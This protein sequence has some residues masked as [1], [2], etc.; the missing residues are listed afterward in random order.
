MDNQQI[1][2]Q[3]NKQAEIFANWAAGKNAEYL[4]AF[5]DFSGIAPDDK[6]LDVA[7]GP[8]EFTC[9]AARKVFAAYGVDISDKEIEIAK[10]RSN[11]LGLGNIYFDRSDVEKIP[12]KD[13]FFSKV[14]CKSA[15]HHFIHPTAVFDEMR[16][17]CIPGG[18]ISIQDIVAFE[19]GYVTSFF[20]SF[21]KLV[22]AS[23]NS[24][25]KTEE[26]NRLFIDHK[27][28]KIKESHFEANLPVKEYIGHAVQEPENR[29]KINALL[30]DGLNDRKIAEY[31]FFNEGELYCKRFGYLILG[32]KKQ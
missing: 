14:V 22:D 21:D 7:C 28:K 18:K 16:R 3:F 29:T 6:L 19:N 23:H 26:L 1:R 24:V 8:G 13:N 15:F 4:Q 9:Y 5:Y 17:C 10:N 31:L 12:Y 30:S 2:N 25:L 20:D 11:Q 27:V 32:E